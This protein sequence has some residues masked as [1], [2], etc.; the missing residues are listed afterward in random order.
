MDPMNTQSLIEDSRRTVGLNFAEMIT[1]A[2]KRKQEK[3]RLLTLDLKR[4]KQELIAEEER[5]NNFIAELSNYENSIE[6]LKS[7]CASLEQTQQQN[8]AE[9]ESLKAEID[10]AVQE[11]F[12]LLDA[13][14]EQCSAMSDRF[15]SAPQR[16]SL[17]TITNE[18]EDLTKE[19]WD[20]SNEIQKSDSENE[21]L[22]LKIATETLTILEIPGSPPSEVTGTTLNELLDVLRENVLEQSHIEEKVKQ[23][24]ENLLKEEEF[25]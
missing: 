24:I 13:H 12:K 20:I 10:I 11:N 23:E 22:E 3:K 7:I 2:S 25:Y 21:I 9:A 15:T 17:E 18:I 14:Q 19:D 4:E 5:E 16:Y 8:N 1:S 6:N